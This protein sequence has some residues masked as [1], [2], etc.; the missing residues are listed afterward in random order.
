MAHDTDIGK[1]TGYE[2]ESMDSSDPE[3][4]DDTSD[5]S[6][7]DDAKRH[8]PT[9]KHYNTNVPLKDLC[10]GLRFPDLKLF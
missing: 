10:L 9:K 2:S 3:S 1:V 4:Y 7:V 6:S 5:G 8:R